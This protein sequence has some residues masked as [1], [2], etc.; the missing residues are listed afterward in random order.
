MNELE[1]R[2]RSALVREATGA[3]SVDGMRDRFW[4]TL[5]PAVAAR[6]A[7]RSWRLPALAAAA[8]VAIIVFASV[9]LSGTV[10]DD[11]VDDLAAISSPRQPTA[12]TDDSPPVVYSEREILAAGKRVFA[13]GRAGDVPPP[14]VAFADANLRR[15]VLEMRPADLKKH[16]V[17]ELEARF[18]EIAGMPVK[19]VE[20]ADQP[21]QP[22][23]P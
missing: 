15:L 10:D 16:D 7:S 8:S 19:V 2:M 12:S 14:N 13:A 23:V 9:A 22:A 1:E 3:P 17:Q 11:D 5:P 21:P 4:S 18:A 20:G 6:A